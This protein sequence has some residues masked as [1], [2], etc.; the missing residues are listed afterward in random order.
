MGLRDAIPTNHPLRRYYRTLQA[1]CKVRRALRESGAVRYAI[2]FPCGGLGDD[3]LG[4]ALARPLAQRTGRPVWM[5]SDHPELFTGQT[6]VGRTLPN[7]TEMAEAVVRSGAQVL[8]TGYTDLLNGGSLHSTPDEHIISVM[9]RRSGFQGRLC[10]RPYFKLNRV[11]LEEARRIGSKI[12]VFQVSAQ[13]ARFPIRT[14]EWFPNR[15]ADVARHF[16]GSHTLVQI[17]S[18]RDPLLPGALDLRGQTNV[19]QTASLLAISDVFVGL[20][21]FLMHLCR[22]VDGR[23]VIIYGGRELPWQSGYRSFEN[24]ST[25]IPCSPC[26]LV[27]HCPNEMQCM[28]RISNSDVISAINRVLAQPR[29]SAPEDEIE[30]AT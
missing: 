26:W 8:T 19:R 22:A 23:A 13:A 6:F 5:L 17:G 14:K 9:A 10:L 11:D 29:L 21:G 1:R 27:D 20:V 16:A 2:R 25:S 18:V 4:T 28:Q 3:L 12:M 24:I 7:T 15:F 30:V